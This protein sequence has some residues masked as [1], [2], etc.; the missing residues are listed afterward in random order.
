MESMEIATMSSRGQIVIPQG[1]RD[2]MALDEGVKFIV[3]GE[4]DTIILKRLEVSSVGELRSLLVRS[5]SAARKSKFKK[6]NLNKIIIQERKR[7]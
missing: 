6:T 2:A 5:R 7:S 3:L 1:V 4:G